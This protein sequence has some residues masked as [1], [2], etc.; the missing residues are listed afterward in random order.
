MPPDVQAHAPAQA[1]AG[2]ERRPRI[3][4]G[5]YGRRTRAAAMTYVGVLAVLIALIVYFAA[6]QSEF[7]TYD[8]FINILETNGVLLIVSVGLTFALLVGGFDLSMG[9]VIA[10]GGVVMA[11]L[12][13][14]GVPTGAAIAVIVVGAFAFGLI[15]NGV[16][17]AKLQLNFF[18]VTLGAWIA[19]QGLAL[20]VSQGA[21]Q[22]LYNNKLIKQIGTLRYGNFPVSVMIALFVA[23]VA[24]V[25]L[26]YTGFG[27][28]MYVVGGNAEAARLAGINV[29][30][31][32]ASAFGLCAMLAGVAAVV[33]S[34]RLASASPLTDLNIALTAAA[35]VLLG[36]TS[37]TGGV[38][39]VVGTLLGVA[40]LGVL[41]NGL[42][43]SSIQVYWQ[44]VITGAVLILSVLLDQIRRRGRVG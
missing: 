44:N 29:V 3:R 21:V 40:F 14:H 24:F 16:P 26:R 13:Q 31:V 41:Q 20:A 39:G 11:K 22:P 36:G 1:Q 19:L 12:I 28:M 23:A 38:G 37:F 2:M 6:T 8:N 7:T 10:F 18:V 4:F 43:L 25:V 34:G 35:A 27:R 42:I 17:I 30:A 32:R 9:G 5:E 15:G 33:E